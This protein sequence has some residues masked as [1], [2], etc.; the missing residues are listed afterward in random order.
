MTHPQPFALSLSKV[1]PQLRW[2]RKNKNSPSTSSGRTEKKRLAS[3]RPS[4]APRA[5][6]EQVA[7]PL[8]VFRADGGATASQLVVQTQADLL[9]H[10]VEVSAVA[11]VSALGAAKLAWE[12]LGERS[13]WP[14]EN[15]GKV[16]TSRL[17]PD[18]RIRRRRN[19]ATEVARARFPP[20]VGS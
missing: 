7:G 15:R 17:D 4:A 6:G 3:L 13:R 18:T 16:V 2:V 5:S 19:R 14:R 11:E 1:C 10:D 20:S 9:G 12:V 8:K